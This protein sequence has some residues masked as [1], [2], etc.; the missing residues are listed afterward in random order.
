MEWLHSR[1]YQVISLEQ[2]ISF[3]N[4][5]RLPPGRS[6]I[7]TF[8][9]G[10]QDNWEIAYRILRDHSFP[11]TIFLV[12]QYVGKTNLWDLDG[13]LTERKLLS[14]ENILEM[15]QNGISFGSHSRSHP[16]LTELSE[17]QLR[18][19]IELSRSELQNELEE[20]IVTFAYPN[21][22]YN[23]KIVSVL[24]DSGFLASCSSDSGVNDPCVPDFSLRRAEI[25]GKYDLFSFA[26][27]LWF[28]QTRVFWRLLKGI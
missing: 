2:L 21:G 12:S 6:V 1:G 22:K 7:I 11:A 9:D 26:L 3:R 19:E 16:R 18:N 13:E 15:A 5:K 8:D 27:T 23:Q 10:Y 4:E 28:G 14:W 24:K 25:S 17:E 20:Q